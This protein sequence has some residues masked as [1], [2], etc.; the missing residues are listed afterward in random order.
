MPM[1]C[2]SDRQSDKKII[3][4]NIFNFGQISKVIRGIIPRKKRMNQNFLWI[5]RSTQY[6]PHTC[7]YTKFHE[8]FCWAISEELCWQKKQTNK[9]KKQK[10]KNQK[11]KKKTTSTKK[12]TIP[13]LTDWL[14]DGWVKIWGI[15]SWGWGPESYRIR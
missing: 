8:S 3:I 9:N 12:K 13:G 1:P 14:T 4:S 2:I 10:K 7:N 15:L 6:V 11:T 5:R